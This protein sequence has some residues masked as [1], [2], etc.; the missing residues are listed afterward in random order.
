MCSHLA[1]QNRR[2]NE[3]YMNMHHTHLHDKGD[4]NDSKTDLKHDMFL[5]TL[6]EHE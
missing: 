2:H 6:S 3:Q 5:C 4:T 1:A